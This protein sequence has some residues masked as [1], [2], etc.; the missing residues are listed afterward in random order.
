MIPAPQLYKP[1][2]EFTQ[3][4]ASTTLGNVA[5]ESYKKFGDKSPIISIEN[6]PYGTALGRA[7]DLKNLIEETRKKFVEKARKEGMSASQA[8]D[9]SK[10]LIGATWD[11][12]H[13]SMMRKQ[14]FG[15]EKLIEEAK[16]IA[17]FVKHVHLN[18]NFGSTHTDLPPGMATV[19]FKEILKEF[20]KAG[21]KGKKVFEGGAFFQHFQTSPHPYVLE[22]LGSPLYGMHMAPYWNQIMATQGNYF[23]GYGQILPDQHFATYGAGFSGM[24]L[25]LG[26]QIPGKQSRFAGAPN[27]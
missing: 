18:D 5:F 22:A 12:S 19:P 8:E 27:Q 17:P 11:T 2:E 24:P 21:V 9:A 6:P 13:I 1:V 16:L 26:G 14:G 10:K 7:E 15:K 4:K 20:E 25:E 23:A 3:E